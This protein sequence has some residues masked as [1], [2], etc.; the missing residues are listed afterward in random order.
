MARHR[1]RTF[2]AAPRKPG[3]RARSLWLPG[4]RVT[5]SR[6]TPRRPVRARAEPS[7]TRTRLTG[8]VALA[9]VRVARTETVTRAPA[10][11]RRRDARNLRRGFDRSGR[12]RGRPGS[13]ANT[14]KTAQLSGLPAIGDWL[15]TST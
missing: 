7:R 6:A 10:R 3:L 4:E 9:S 14:S 11:T 15:V 12:Y 8:R 2:K 1:A 5:R 13:P